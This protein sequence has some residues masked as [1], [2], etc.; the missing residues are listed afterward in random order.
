[1][2]ISKPIFRFLSVAVLLVGLAGYNFIKAYDESIWFPPAGNPPTQNVAAPINV[3]TTTQMKNGDFA[4]DTIVGFD[5]VHASQYC[6]V[7]GNHCLDLSSCNVGDSLVLQSSGDWGCPSPDVVDYASYVRTNC[8]L[9]VPNPG[10]LSLHAVVLKNGTAYD[11]YDSGS[12][13]SLLAWKCTGSDLA[14]N[15]TLEAA[16]GFSVP[17]PGS[18]SLNTVQLKNGSYYD[19]FDSGSATAVLKWNCTSAD[20]KITSLNTSCGLTVPNPGSVSLNTVQLKNGSY[21][22]L[23]DSGSATAV[24]TWNCQ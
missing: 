8:G 7:N 13:Y 10:S 19:L 4:A 17:N 24:L 9:T 20:P 21:Y 3:G 11:L 12:A 18:V 6:D 16:C 1:M 2:Y 23:Y 14:T 22:D 15:N 5:A